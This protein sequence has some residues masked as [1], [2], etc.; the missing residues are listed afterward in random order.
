MT[1]NVTLNYF[2]RYIF[3]GLALGA[4]LGQTGVVTNAMINRAAEAL[5]ELINEDDLAR[6]AT[7]PENVDIREIAC[8]LAAKVFEQAVEEKLVVSSQGGGLGQ[9]HRVKLLFSRFPTK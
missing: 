5:V 4:A 8:H 2:C 7:F 3:P 6:R 9:N 1:L